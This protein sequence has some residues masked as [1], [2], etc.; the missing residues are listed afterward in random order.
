MSDAGQV[1]DDPE[2]A[3][4]SAG[5]AKCGDDRALG[6]RDGA[7]GRDPL[8]RLLTRRLGE[9]E[10]I[11]IEQLPRFDMFEVEPTL[12]GAGRR[13]AEAAIAV[14]DQEW[15]PGTGHESKLPTS[16]CARRIRCSNP[17]SYGMKPLRS[18]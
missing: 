14:E 16:G 10:L 11:E 4:E 6:A 15:A 5:M 13:R 17:S 18:G 12:S 2:C 1:H 7:V 3:P 8:N 9:T